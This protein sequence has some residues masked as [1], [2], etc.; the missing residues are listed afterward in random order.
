MLKTTRAECNTLIAP[1][2]TLHFHWY[3]SATELAAMTGVFLPRHSAAGEC[4]GAHH[5]CRVVQYAS[6]L[7]LQLGLFVCGR[8]IAFTM[9]F[10]LLATSY[11]R[12]TGSRH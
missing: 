5:R 3:T 9:P 4:Q 7:S 8:T 2:D 6:R 11:P 1:S 10:S 12:K